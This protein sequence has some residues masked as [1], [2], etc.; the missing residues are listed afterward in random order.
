MSEV[1]VTPPKTRP[2][3]GRKIVGV[4]GEI[5]ITLGLI[6]AGFIVYQV[7]WTGVLAD[8]AQEEAVGQFASQLE[9]NW[10][11]GESRRDDPP[12]FDKDPAPAETYGLIHIPR[13]GEEW[14]R[15][16]AEGVDTQSVLHT[17]AYGHYE[18]TAQPGEL[19]NFSLAAHRAGYGD[20][21]IGV[22]EL[23]DGDP[24]IIETEDRYYVYRIMDRE[25]VYPQDVRVISED[26]IAARNGEPITANKRYLTLTTCHPLYV[27]NQRYIVYSELDYWVDREDGLPI[28][29]VPMDERPDNWE[30][31]Y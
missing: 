9:E 15:T 14:V 2:S 4:I 7:W 22:E 11:I 16:I 25:I 31:I 12:A 10:T 26:P 20:P 3:I 27:S 18:N 13:F 6:L 1:A 28:D 17:G 21:L 8:R 19:G 29:L 5:L 24:I 23:E 30:E